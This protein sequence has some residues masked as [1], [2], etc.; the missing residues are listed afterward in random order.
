MGECVLRFVCTVY[1]PGFD[2]QYLQQDLTATN[3][4]TT[5]TTKGRHMYPRT[6]LRFSTAGL[7]ESDESV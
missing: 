6:M 7:R 5:F 3:W 4:S 2:H 1:C